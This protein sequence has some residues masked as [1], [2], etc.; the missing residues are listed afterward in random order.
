MNLTQQLI[1]VF[2]SLIIH[3]NKRTVI[4]IAKEYCKFQTEYPK[5]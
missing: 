4:I 5:T 2:I 1:Y 3:F